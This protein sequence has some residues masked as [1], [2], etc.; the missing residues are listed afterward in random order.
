MKQKSITEQ[1]QAFPWCISWTRL[2]TLLLRWDLSSGKPAARRAHIWPRGKKNSLRSWVAPHPGTWTSKSVR[3]WIWWKQWQRSPQRSLVPFT[4]AAT[5]AHVGA[6]SRHFSMV[7][8]ALF[9]SYH[10]AVRSLNTLK[11]RNKWS[12]W[13]E[14]WFENQTDNQFGVHENQLGSSDADPAL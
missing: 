4:F 10:Q 6:A 3:T 7:T 8:V 11:I 14:R 9:E 2:R 13:A 1:C 12:E 5:V